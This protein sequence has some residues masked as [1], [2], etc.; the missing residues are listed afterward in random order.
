MRV[1]GSAANR[2]DSRLICLGCS[3]AVF[4]T[5]RASSMVRRKECNTGSHPRPKFNL[6][7]FRPGERLRAARGGIA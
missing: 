6:T 2:A 7:I 1:L 3:F 5:A 4:A